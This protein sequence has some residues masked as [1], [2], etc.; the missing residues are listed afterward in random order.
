MDIIE[1]LVVHALP[2]TE[3]RVQSQIALVQAL[4]IAPTLSRLDVRLQYVHLRIV[5]P[6][7]GQ[8]M[9]RVRTVIAQFS[10]HNL[11][12]RDYGNGSNRDPPEHCEG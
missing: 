5:V 6:S 7:R 4:F 9:I 8:P 2:E 10:A 12:S 11:H 1:V 3:I